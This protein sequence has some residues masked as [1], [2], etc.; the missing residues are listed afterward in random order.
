MS[1]R[2]TVV[3][4]TGDVRGAGTDARVYVTLRG[5]QGTSPRLPLAGGK[6]L[7]ERGRTDTFAVDT[8]DVGELTGLTVE[9]DNTGMAPGWFLERVAVR[10]A[11]GREWEFP[12]HNWLAK[13]E[14]DRRTSRD[15]APLPQRRN[16]PR[17]SAAPPQATA[18]ADRPARSGTP[19]KTPRAMP[20]KGRGEQS[21]P[22]QVRPAQQQQQQQQSQQRQQFPQFPVAPAAPRARRYRVSTETGDVRGAGT[23]AKVFVTLKGTRGQSSRVQLP[24]AKDLFEKGRTDSFDIEC[25]DVGDLTS[26]VV[27][28]DN[29]G[30]GAGWFLERLLVAESEAPGQQWRYVVKFETG[31]VAGAGTD[32]NVSINLKG[33]LGSTGRQVLAADKGCF[34]KGKTDVFEITCDWVGQLVSATVEHDNTGLA[35]G[36]FLERVSV[37]ESDPRG[38]IGMGAGW[39]LE[40]LLVAESEAPRRQWV[41]P[42]HKWLAKDEGDG[43][44]CRELLQKYV[45]KFETGNVKGAGTDANVSITIKGTKGMLVEHDNTGLAPGWF[46]ERVV[47]EEADPRGLVWEF[48]CNAWL[49]VDEA[50]AST[51]H[52][53]IVSTY[54][55]DTPRAGTDARVFVTLF[56]ENGKPSSRISLTKK[57]KNLFERGQRDDFEVSLPELLGE[58]S[59]VLVS[60]DNS[61]MD[62]SWFLDKIVVREADP[63]SSSGPAA[64]PGRVWEFPCGAWLA[65]DRGDRQ[66]SRELHLRAPES[67]KAASKEPPRKY[68]I[69]TVT[70]NAFGSGTD[71]N[72]FVTL[73]GD[74]AESGRRRLRPPRGRNPFERGQRDDFEI[75][76]PVELGDLQKVIVSHDN[77][78]V[79]PSWF[80]EEV[81][82]RELFGAAR[83]WHFQCGRW[84]A[85]NK[86]DGRLEHTDTAR[87]LREVLAVVDSWPPN[88]ANV[89]ESSAR[90]ALERLLR[91]ESRIAASLSDMSLAAGEAM[92]KEVA[93][94]IVRVLEIRAKLASNAA[95]GSSTPRIGPT[96]SAPADLPPLDTRAGVVAVH[97]AQQQAQAARDHQQPQIPEFA[98]DSVEIPA[99]EITLLS[100]IGSGAFGTVYRARCRGKM[101][102]AKVPLQQTLTDRQ[103]AMFRHEMSIMRKVYHPHVVLFLGACTAPGSVIIVTELLQC[104]LESVLYG[105]NRPE[106][107]LTD[108]LKMALDAAVGLNWLHGI[109]HIAHRDLKPANLLLDENRRVKVADFGFSEILGK[110]KAPK[111]PGK[112]RG[113]IMYAAPELLMGLEWD[114]SIDVY[115]FG[116]I[117]YELITGQ[118]LFPGWEEPQP[119]MKA[120]CYDEMR[121]SIP[122]ETPAALARLMVDCWGAAP[123]D[124]PKMDRVVRRLEQS[125]V[126][127]TITEQHAGDFWK[128]YFLNPL[129]ERVS[130]RSFCKAVL[131]EMGQD[132]SCYFGIK[133][134]LGGDTVQMDHVQSFALWF[135][136]L[137]IDTLVSAETLYRQDWFHGFLDRG[138]AETRLRDRRNGTFLVRLSATEP[139]SS[140]FTLSL[141][142]GGAVRHKRILRNTEDEQQSLRVGLDGNQWVEADG[143]QG[144]VDQLLE[145]MVISIPCPKEELPY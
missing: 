130:W 105:E 113:T 114:F 27:E 73:V 94:G 133:E 44:I 1:K 112:V 119:F 36:W 142:A 106:V 40:R 145:L 123:A 110:G 135:G 140:P 7:F 85:K 124:R 32:A 92:L 66:T 18:E 101:V 71:A 11:A 120:I 50:V 125:V 75:E 62:P 9:H 25:A 61:G 69:S 95:T 14:A 117:L 55:G 83:E 45:V 28:H 29:S 111:N 64:I 68:G 65:A 3:V 90:T 58:L 13:D 78:G 137:S 96:G 16:S 26:A 38:K 126:D 132:I 102:A 54:T 99:A 41:L 47:V 86:D 21:S 42:C 143:L 131:K 136:E 91:V 138:V 33:T 22:E 100:K 84:L 56:G 129:Q 34:E 116:Y 12:C 49:A 17:S 59:R 46:L 122:D 79:N 52:R 57:G 93:N 6:E 87:E 72:V 118:A 127:T 43:L 37:E 67:P 20:A 8:D 115:A 103:L 63:P 81:I 15:L 82:V 19:R 39:F 144:L 77:S 70:G 89:D 80:L 97:R 60:H 48:P 109:C 2:Y 121:P 74:A 31:N 53:Y 76:A 134:L 107:S 24:D 104:D 128:K 88:A 108:R 98:G 51:H 23:D 141:L 35:P 5:T 4:V 30:M 139:T 10:D